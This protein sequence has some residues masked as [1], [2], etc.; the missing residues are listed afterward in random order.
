[1]RT[2]SPRGASVPGASRLPAKLPWLTSN[3]SSATQSPTASL[4]LRKKIKI[5]GSFVTDSNSS[6]N[7]SPTTAKPAT[8]PATAEKQPLDVPAKNPILEVDPSIRAVASTPSLERSQ[9]NPKPRKLSLN[10]TTFPPSQPAPAPS[11]LPSVNTAIPQPG[12]VG[13]LV[14]RAEY[15]PSEYSS[16]PPNERKYSFPHDIGPKSTIDLTPPLVDTSRLTP[17]PKAPLRSPSVE[18]AGEMFSVREVA[19]SELRP[20]DA[21]VLHNTVQP[22]RRPTMESL[23]SPLAPPSPRT[24]AR[25][26]IQSLPEARPRKQ[27]QPVPPSTKRPSVI[28]SEEDQSK[29]LRRA[30][31]GLEAV[32]QE[33]L[34]VAKEAVEANK[35]EEVAEILTEA[36]L[37]LKNA[38]TVRGYMIDP[39]RLSES[40]V[41]ISSDT[42]TSITDSSSSADEC[43][44]IDTA[45]TFL[46]KSAYSS[47]QPIL[48]APY[49]RDRK[50][51]KSE[52]AGADHSDKN[53]S[54]A[55]TPPRLY[56]PHSAD[57][58]VKDFA[59]SGPSRKSTH[60]TPRT[61]ASSASDEPTMGLPPTLA[62]KPGHEKLNFVDR[63]PKSPR[64]QR[65]D[66]IYDSVA[67]PQGRQLRQLEPVPTDATL[68]PQQNV[69]QETYT[70]RP[71]RRHRKRQE[72]SGRHP[73]AEKV[74]QSNYYDVPDR[75][76][77]ED[78]G[79]RGNSRYES[80]GPMSPVL[81]LKHPFRR[82]HISL[83][84]GQRWRLERRKRQ[85]I[86]REWKMGRKRI[87]AAI[88]CLNTALIGLLIGIYVRVQFA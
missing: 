29:S 66:T 79:L 44:S 50:R 27:S 26:S 40:D 63:E 34:H 28:S 85:P 60:H 35:P 33:A 16:T 25:P 69:S 23:P 88:A 42:D 57:S 87:T 82:N 52:E 74:F 14:S 43:G 73:Y 31:T 7:D 45:P 17:R 54:I 39:L 76:L 80:L 48:S 20:S 9:A 4:A 68:A 11:S 8:K 12:I 36:N 3:S 65:R 61:R 70:Q 18:R 81:S 13:K 78:A 72:H 67:G 75:N 46:T 32:M 86:A 5:P 64:D 19:K 37:A 2:T 51:P 1:M 47:R 58:I 49:Q 62:K 41:G 55:Q 53:D 15:T 38:A 83:R 30:V 21:T 6:S 84:E 77:H 71:H 59:Y 22:S 24:A 56:Q 10:Y